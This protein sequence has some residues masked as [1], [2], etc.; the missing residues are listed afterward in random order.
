VEVDGSFGGCRSGADSCSNYADCNPQPGDGPVVW[1]CD[2]GRRT[3]SSSISSN[4]HSPPLWAPS[5]TSSSSFAAKW[6][7]SDPRHSFDIFADA[8]ARDA[9]SG[10]DGGGGGGN[11]YWSCSTALARY[12][13]IYDDLKLCSECAASHT[14]VL[15]KAG[16]TD[17]YVA[18]S[19]SS[20]F[21]QCAAAVGA[22]V[23]TSV[24]STLYQTPNF[25]APPFE[26][27]KFHNMHC[28]LLAGR[29]VCQTGRSTRGST[30]DYISTR[31]S[32]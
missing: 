13:P 19:C 26:N 23:I 24:C 31:Y 6:T 8:G 7:S 25:I 28:W 22:L 18:Q 15:A 4:T 29:S 14:A 16:C 1:E 17:R 10:G 3:A 2:C 30:V 27:L 20:D 21:H 12:C 32:I 9:I 11:G 5:P